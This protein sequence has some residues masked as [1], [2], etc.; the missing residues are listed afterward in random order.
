MRRSFAEKNVMNFFHAQKYAADSQYYVNA[1][2][3][4]Y[5]SINHYYFY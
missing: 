2:I 5:S 1:F 3:A 4:Y